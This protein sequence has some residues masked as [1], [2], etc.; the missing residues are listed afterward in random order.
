MNPANPEVDCLGRSV[1]YCKAA[2]VGERIPPKMASFPQQGTPEELNKNGPSLRSDGKGGAN[3]PTGKCKMHSWLPAA[4]TGEKLTMFETNL[5]HRNQPTKKQA[6]KF[7]SL[8]S[9]NN[10]T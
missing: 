1:A 6:A 2:V 3:L 10:G 7:K 8:E 9:E 5:L 4:C